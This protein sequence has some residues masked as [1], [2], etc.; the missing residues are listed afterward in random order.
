MKT[1]RGK[2]LWQIFVGELLGNLRFACG[3]G[4][5]TAEDAEEHRGKKIIERA[6]LKSKLQF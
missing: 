1:P 2:S 5:L 3:R 4:V 6:R